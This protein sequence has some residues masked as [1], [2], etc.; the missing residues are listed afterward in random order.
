V[1]SSI[2]SGLNAIS[3]NKLKNLN[4]I[5]SYIQ[6]SHAIYLLNTCLIFTQRGAKT[7]RI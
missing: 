1:E 5:Q 6:F 4:Y 2:R 7:M 3:D